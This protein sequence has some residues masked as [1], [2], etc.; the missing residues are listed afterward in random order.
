L[1]KFI[2]VYKKLG[3]LPEHCEKIW[4]TAVFKK[5]HHFMTDKSKWIKHSFRSGTGI[6][7]TLVWKL[8]LRY[9]AQ[10]K[11]GVIGQ[12]ITS[13]IF[14]NLIKKMP[15]AA[16]C[17]PKQGMENIDMSS[18]CSTSYERNREQDVMKGRA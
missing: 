16:H 2:V 13:F 11:L 7:K 6:S 10:G 9:P 4:E 5:T 1:K 3:Y 17:S 18:N 14:A 12:I 8:V 15:K